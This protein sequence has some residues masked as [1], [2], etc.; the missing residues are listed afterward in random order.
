M[1]HWNGRDGGLTT[2]AAARLESVLWSSN[3]VLAV[4]GYSA[5]EEDRGLTRVVLEVRMGGP[6][7]VARP[8][9][10]LRRLGVPLVA[11]LVHL[12]VSDV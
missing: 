6:L 3:R 1:R 12:G 9:A 4:F 11:G 8:R 10:H 7:M 2:S 5:T